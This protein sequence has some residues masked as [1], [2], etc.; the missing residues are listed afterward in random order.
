MFSYNRYITKKRTPL[1]FQNISNKNILSK[2]NIYKSKKASKLGNRSTKDINKFLKY[3][4]KYNNSSTQKNNLTN[5]QL[6]IPKENIL[7]ILVKYYNKNEIKKTQKIIE[8]LR[9]KI[10]NFQ[11]KQEK[12]SK[13]IEEL[14]KE[15][16]TFINRYK[17]S[18]LLS[19]KNNSQFLK[20]GITQKTID[21]FN[22]LGYKMNDII[23]KTNI[24]DKSLLL[25][26]QYDNFVKYITSTQNAELINDTNYISKINDGLIAKKNSELFEVNKTHYKKRQSKYSLHNND[27]SEEEVKIST[28]Q[29]SNTFNDINKTL[30][31]INN[32]N[33]LKGD[34]KDYHKRGKENESIQELK[35]NIKNT[36]ISLNE[37]EKEIINKNSG[38]NQKNNDFP[39]IKNRIDKIKKKYGFIKDDNNRNKMFNSTSS[40]Y[41]YISLSTSFPEKTKYLINKDLRNSTFISKNKINKDLLGNEPNNTKFDYSM[42][43]SFSVPSSI[44]DISTCNINDIYNNN[45]KTK[46]FFNSTYKYHKRR[47][48][49]LQKYKTLIDKNKNITSN[50]DKNNPI[51]E[52]LNTHKDEKRQTK[53]EEANN[54]KNNMLQHLYNNIQ[55]K[56]F[57]ENKKEISDYLK[58]YKGTN[59]KEPNYEKGSKL[60]NLINNFLNKSADYNL[61]D[62]INKI[63]SRTNVFD[64]KKAMQYD[65]I[66]KLNNR[67]QNLMYDC[68]ENILDLNNDIKK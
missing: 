39:L 1:I 16:K 18:G 6:Y 50:E 30:N 25:N 61:P 2:L 49:N 56:T 57:N 42:F 26:K 21:E 22:Y 46:N 17:L 59:I 68:A 14:R 27:N 62:E 63:R 54:L 23:N 24:F 31:M 35:K 43:N 48:N 51:N 9:N 3:K 64:Y 33:Y 47:S 45:K 60:Y 44:K 28:I 65:E 11:E 8:P 4:K 15:T 36:N 10:Y 40:I 29:L 32:K 13:E 12:T 34:Y 55:L 52:D 41:N 37:L 19:P 67:I 58:I 20:L 53:K 5:E 7:R 66:K 38:E